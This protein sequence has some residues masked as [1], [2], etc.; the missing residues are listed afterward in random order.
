MNSILEGL[1][2]ITCLMDDILIF[3]KG[4]TQHDTRLTR[5]LERLKVVGVTLNP[6]KCAFSE[7]L[8]TYH[9]QRW[10]ECRSREN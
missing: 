3:G 5:V 7:I 1:D 2:G 9:R 8:G 4:E 6:D 10:G